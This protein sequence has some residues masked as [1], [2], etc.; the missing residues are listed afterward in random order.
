MI[1]KYYIRYYLLAKKMGNRRI[2]EEG[3]VKN[4][5]KWEKWEMFG[6]E[7]FSELQKT[8]KYNKR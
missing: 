5:E 3:I 7:E 2:K 1:T 6:K 4:K 8:Y